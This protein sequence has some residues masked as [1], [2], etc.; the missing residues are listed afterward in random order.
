MEVTGGWVQKKTLGGRSADARGFPV[1]SPYRKTSA[2]LA[3]T[4]DVFGAS[5][6]TT[7]RK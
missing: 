6:L 3:N 7:G 1:V 2:A 5:E 4:F